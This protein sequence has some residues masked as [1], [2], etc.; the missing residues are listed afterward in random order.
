MAVVRYL[1]ERGRR[2]SVGE[3]KIPIVPAAILFE[4]QIGDREAEAEP[5]RPKIRPDSN[6]GYQAAKAATSGQVSEGI[7]RAMKS[8]VRTYSVTLSSGVVEFPIDK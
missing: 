3:L 7:E 6:C 5:H 1:E 2:F 4:L 8:G